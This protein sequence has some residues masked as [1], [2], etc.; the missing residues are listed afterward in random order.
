MRY[1]TL[2]FIIFALVGCDFSGSLTDSVGSAIRKQVR[3]NGAQQ[4]DLASVVPFKWDELYL[5][6]PYVPASQVC[7]KL[8]IP[9]SQCASVINQA[10]MDDG[11]MYMVF[12]LDGKI[13]HQEMYRRF[14]GDFTPIDY[15]MPIK[16]ESAKFTVVNSGGKTA[17]GKP[18][19]KLMPLTT[20]VTTEGTEPSHVKPKF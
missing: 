5:F 11:D 10:S 8:T 18:W 12:K 16:K 15:A 20:E 14:N 13:I 6:N 9:E 19:L 4:I 7:K 17:S 3:D 2:T 1:I